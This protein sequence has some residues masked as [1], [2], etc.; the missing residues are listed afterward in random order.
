MIWKASATCAR[1]EQALVSYITAEIELACNPAVP[2]S[3]ACPQCLRPS[4]CRRAGRPAEEAEPSSTTGVCRR[5]LAEAIATFI[6]HQRSEFADGPRRA[7]FGRDGALPAEYLLLLIGR[8][9]WSVGCE[10]TARRLLEA[11]LRAL[12]L[13]AAFMEAVWAPDASMAHWY[14]LFSTRALRTSSLAASSN[15]A[16]WVLDLERMIMPAPESL[17]LLALTV[18]RTVID[19]LAALWD[20]CQGHGVLGLRH[21]KAVASGMLGVPAHSAKAAALAAEIRA[22]VERRLAML[23]AARGWNQIPQVIMLDL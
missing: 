4:R 12:N 18:V 8:A 19:R 1:A 16:L 20:H 11:Q 17:E 5:E 6:T 9:L 14:I 21:A 23:K 3:I 7:F 13:P 15:G 10:Q 2:D 22:E